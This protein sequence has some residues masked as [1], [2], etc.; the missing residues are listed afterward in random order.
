[1]IYREPIGGHSA[2]LR[3]HRDSGRG[4][5]PIREVTGHE[6]GGTL[7]RRHRARHRGTCRRSRGHMP[8]LGGTTAL[9][10]YRDLGGNITGYSSSF[11]RL[12]AYWGRGAQGRFR[13]SEGHLVGGRGGGGSRRHLG[14]G[15]I[16]QAEEATGQARR[17]A[18][19]FLDI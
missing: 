17:R 18:V 7:S 1:L 12:R 13:R 3:G 9:G 15:R 10:G 19:T 8:N 14:K 6:G 16:P 11:H 4:V 5:L 2:A